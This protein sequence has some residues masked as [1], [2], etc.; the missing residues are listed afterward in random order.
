[1]ETNT[2][3][4]TATNKSPEDELAHIRKT[5]KKSFV[6]LQERLIATKGKMEKH[7]S[8]VKT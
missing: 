4:N 1:M 3:T 5:D 7:I 8:E 2:E 6:R